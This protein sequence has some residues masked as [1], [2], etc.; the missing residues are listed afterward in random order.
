MALTLNDDQAAALLDALGLPA[1]TDD[2]DLIAQTAAD[3]AAQV[4]DTAMSRPSS[5]AAAARTHGMEAVDGDT[6]AALR[7]DAAEGRQLKAAA[8][9][10]KVE[11]AVDDAI[12]TGRI[13]ASRKKHWLTLCETDGEMVQHLASIAPG[14]AVPLDAV[15]HATERADDEGTGWFY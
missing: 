13:M 6:V 10:A 1:D 5:V 9:R 12:N 8:A 11:A 7:R 15:G 3:L 2:V 4:A 14:T